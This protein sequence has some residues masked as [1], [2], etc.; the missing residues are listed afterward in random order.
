LHRGLWLVYCH[1]PLAKVANQAN[2][3]SCHK[4]TPPAN[5]AKLANFQSK[6]TS[7]ALR[8][9][10]PR[11]SVIPF[12]SNG[13]GQV[14]FEGVFPDF[15]HVAAALLQQESP[16]EKAD[17]DRLAMADGWMPPIVPVPFFSDP[18]TPPIPPT[19][20]ST[21]CKALPAV[22]KPAADPDL[23]FVR[24]ALTANI[25]AA[26]RARGL[27]FRMDADGDLVIQGKGLTERDRLLFEPHET[28]IVEALNP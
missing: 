26:S 9:G 25:F 2:L 28:A 15:D 3:A 19:A 22:A 24:S 14:S 18:P 17:N 1:T 4:D 13:S 6:D 8:Y 16:E 21:S 20:V 11:H 10:Q 27:T 23:D 12:P 5:A 7:V